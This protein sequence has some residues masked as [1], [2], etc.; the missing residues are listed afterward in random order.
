VYRVARL[1]PLALDAAISPDS[2]EQE[3]AAAQLKHRTL[4]KLYNEKPAW[5][6][7]AHADLDAAVA[8]AYGWP[9][10]LTDD[11]LLNNLLALNLSR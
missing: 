10:N 4:T 8:A 7:H 1:T 3:R 2:G 6:V 9:A 5:L 11:A